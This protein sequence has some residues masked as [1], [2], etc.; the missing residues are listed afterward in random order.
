M[1]GGFIK[2]RKIN[3]YFNS[4]TPNLLVVVGLGHE[5]VRSTTAHAKV[6]TDIRKNKEQETSRG[7]VSPPLEKKGYYTFLNINKLPIHA[8]I[9]GV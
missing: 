6:Q 2:T 1:S 5:L 3:S 9:Q 4:A 7:G 8:E